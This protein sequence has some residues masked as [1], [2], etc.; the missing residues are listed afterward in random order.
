MSNLERLLKMVGKEPRNL[1]EI[2]L[3]LKGGN[4]SEEDLMR[5]AIKA[6]GIYESIDGCDKYYEEI[7]RSIGDDEFIDAEGRYYKV[8]KAYDPYFM[9]KINNHPLIKI[10]EELL[11]KGL[12]P[13]VCLNH[14]D[15]TNVMCELR[16]I[17]LPFLGAAAMRLLLE[18]GANIYVAGSDGMEMFTDVDSDVAIDIDLLPDDIPQTTIQTWFV[19]VGYGGRPEKVE[20]FHLNPG[21]TYDELKEFEFFD[22]DI[23]YDQEKKE[24]IM[25]ITD[26]RTGEEIGYL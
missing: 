2:E 10:L 26:I 9:H 16:W 24:N 19:L 4:F 12:D 8:S 23:I 18:H 11:E 22:Y 13:S 17:D 5:I 1:N 3:A 25:H 21:H 20:P 14:E 7:N 15:E 6:V